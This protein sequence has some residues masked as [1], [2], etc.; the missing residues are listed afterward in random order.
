MQRNAEKNET[1]YSS[2]QASQLLCEPLR[3]R[4]SAS[5]LPIFRQFLA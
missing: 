3:R 5:T 2:S 4:V 1:M